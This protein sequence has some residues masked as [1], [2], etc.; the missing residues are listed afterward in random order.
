MT[1]VRPYR[2]RARPRPEPPTERFIDTY[3]LCSILHEHQITALNKSNPAHKSFDPDHPKP[4]KGRPARLIGGGI[5]TCLPTSRCCGH[6]AMSASAS[7]LARLIIRPTSGSPRDVQHRRHHTSVPEPYICPSKREMSNTIQFPLAVHNA[8]IKTV[9][10]QIET[11]TV[12]RKQVTLSLLRQLREEPL[13]DSTGTLNGVPWGYVNY[14]PGKGCPRSDHWHIVWQ[15]GRELLRATERKK[16]VFAD[17]YSSEVVTRYLLG[18]LYRV[19]VSGG[20]LSQFSERNHAGGGS[21]L[22]DHFDKTRSGVRA[23]AS[24]P[25]VLLDLRKALETIADHA[26]NNGDWYVKQ[27]EKARRTCEECKAKFDGGE[28]LEAEFNAELEAEAARRQRHVNLRE[29][30]AALPQLFIAV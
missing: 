26:D 6:A 8:E 27:V 16:C 21:R 28:M 20:D 11:M 1:D 24:V 3:E 4:V 25:S 23:G 30:M 9:T 5:R 22:Q 15:R 19:L 7:A 12:G 13:I 14:C 17:Y 10:V 29:A 18:P 2:D